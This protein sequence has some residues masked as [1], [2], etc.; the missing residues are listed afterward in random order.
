MTLIILP[1]QRPATK[2]LE[3]T[4]VT[5][6]GRE[7]SLT[8]TAA[9]DV[10]ESSVLADLCASMPGLA[11]LSVKKADDPGLFAVIVGMAVLWM[12]FGFA[13]GICFAVLGLADFIDSYSR[14]AEYFPVAGGERVGKGLFRLWVAAI[15]IVCIVVPFLMWLVVRNDQNA[16]KVGR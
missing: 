3:F 16:M 10:A 1:L 11:D 15:P 6:S 5:G 13:V 4:G 8:V 14:W 7:V 12:L 2:S 9:V